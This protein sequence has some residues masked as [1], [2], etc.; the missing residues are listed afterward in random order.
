MNVIKKPR[1]L[2]DI[3]SIKSTRIGKI[4]IFRMRGLKKLCTR[5]YA[6]LTRR[7]IIIRKRLSLRISMI[8]MSH[9]LIDIFGTKSAINTGLHN[10]Q[11]LKQIMT[12]FRLEI[13]QLKCTICAQFHS[14]IFFGSWFVYDKVD[15]LY[16]ISNCVIWKV[17]VVVTR[18][19]TVT[20]ECHDNV[21]Y[22]IQVRSSRS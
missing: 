6:Y 10:L 17:G 7:Y 8:Y 3:Q 19:H 18:F 14:N 2:T 13:A 21:K 20:Q 11:E 9:R 12:T 15:E 5:F 4:F 16:G 22:R 1:R